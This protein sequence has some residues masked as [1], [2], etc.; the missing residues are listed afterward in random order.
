MIRTVL[1]FPSDRTLEETEKRL[2]AQ[3][4]AD[5][6]APDEERL[7]ASNWA[8]TIGASPGRPPPSWV[9]PVAKAGVK[10]ELPNCAGAKAI[11][12]DGLRSEMPR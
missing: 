2:G 11:E 6:D 8:L 3:G 9:A 7:Q 5:A 12:A 10:N 4:V 1:P